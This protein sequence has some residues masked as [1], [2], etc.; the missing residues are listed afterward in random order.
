M[1]GHVASR[2][3][4]HRRGTGRAAHPSTVQERPL[5]WDEI[6]FIAEVSPWSP[7]KTVMV[8][9]TGGKAVRTDVPDTL[10][11]EFVAYARAHGTAAQWE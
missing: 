8:T 5:G 9:T 7:T 11:E 10:H 6:A 1:V 4:R 3:V 2:E